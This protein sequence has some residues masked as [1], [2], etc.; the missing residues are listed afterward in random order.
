MCGI[1]GYIANRKLPLNTMVSALEHRGPDAFGLYESTINNKFV[2]LGHTRLSILDLSENGNQP[3]VSNDKKVQLVFN[4]EIYNFKELKATYLKNES[5]KSN[6]DTEVILKLYQ[7]KGISFLDFLNGDFAI[8]ILDENENKFY[9]IRDRAGVKPLYFSFKNE[10]LIFGSEIKSIL[11]AGVKAELEIENLQKYFVFKYSPANET[12]FKNINRLKAGHFAVYDINDSSFQIKKYWEPHQKDK[13]KGI[14]FQDAQIEIKSLLQDATEKRLIADVPVGTFLSGGLDSSIIAS[15]LKGNENIMHYCASKETKDLIKEG[16]TSDFKY[17]QQLANE[18]HLNMTEIP[19]GSDNTNIEQI[20]NTIKYSDD[21][22]AD[23]SQIPSFLITQKAAEQ[24]KV[25]LS[26]MGAD[27]IFLGYAGHQMTLLDGWLG[28]L[29]LDKFIAKKLYS[30]DQGNGRLKAFRRYLHKLGKYY[31]YPNYKYG[32]YTIV[33]DFE[34]SLSIFKGDTEATKQMLSNYFPEGKDPYEC[35]KTF[36]F[37]NFL[38][39]NVAYLDRMTM[40]NGVEGR[41][42]FLDHR[43]IEFAHSIPRKYKLS[44]SG[45]T[46]TVL[47]EAFKN[48]LP[49]YV[50]NRRKAGFGMPL[51]SIFSSEKKINDLLD[52]E[53]LVSIDGFSMDDIEKSIQSHLSG[54]EDNSALIY[55]LISFQE[56]Y[57]MYILD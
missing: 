41:V 52:R 30:I 54:R 43:V 7:Q 46:K 31:N 14:S 37:E 49:N 29:P 6:T 45:T 3:F 44:N 9:L 38:Q 47:K 40:A 39:K 27:E 17:A 4:G 22:I 57:K 42:P 15:F 33:G 55:A 36:E 24:S 53:L 34:N 13:Y 48:D 21:L 20:R 32:L 25:I 18:W 28:K 12:L 11:K 10:E 5:Y 8:A 35:F 23:G 51:R 16:T 56:W 50:T 26:G 1:T 19:I 2:G